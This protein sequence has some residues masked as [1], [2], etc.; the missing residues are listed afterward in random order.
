MQPGRKSL[1][2]SMN[3]VALNLIAYTII[4]KSH[5]SATSKSSDEFMRCLLKKLSSEV[6]Q[7]GK[8]TSVSSSIINL[9]KILVI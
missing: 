5:K 7:L 8:Y 1:G 2:F 9:V 3:A 6:S 4:K